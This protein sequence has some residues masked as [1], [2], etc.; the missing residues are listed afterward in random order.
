MQLFLAIEMFFSPGVD[1]DKSVLTIHHAKD[2]SKRLG[3]RVQVL[4]VSFVVANK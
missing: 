3:L 1:S 4:L 2:T